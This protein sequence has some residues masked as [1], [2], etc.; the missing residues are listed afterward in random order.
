MKISIICLIA[1]CSL[2]CCN[3]NKQQNANTS[4]MK[5]TQNMPDAN[6]EYHFH[7][8]DSASN[9]NVADSIYTCCTQSIK[10]MEINTSI[11]AQSDGTLLGKLSF[12]KVDLQKW[13]EWYEKKYGNKMD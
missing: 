10:F 12:S 11:D 13:H 9:A 8:L 2:I 7:I 6:F 1:F 4:E 3:N 5:N